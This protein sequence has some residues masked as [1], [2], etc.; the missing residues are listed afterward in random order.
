MGIR[1]SSLAYRMIKWLHET[2]TDVCE[3]HERRDLLNRPWE[4]EYLHWAR[5]EH[6]WQL[7]G[8]YVPPRRWHCSV[9]TQGWCL[10]KSTNAQGSR[11]RPQPS[12]SMLSSR[13]RR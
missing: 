4:E 7:H 1:I 2:Y 8:R 12:P 3:L 11:V 5:D 10:A 6:G 13:N 9:T